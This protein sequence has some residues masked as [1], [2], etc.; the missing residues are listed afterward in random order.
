MGTGLRAGSAMAGAQGQSF[1]PSEPQIPHC[2]KGENR[3]PWGYAKGVV[4]TA[5]GPGQTPARDMIAVKIIV[6]ILGSGFGSSIKKIPFSCFL[7]D[8]CAEGVFTLL[9]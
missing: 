6:S 2:K 8:L 4:P 5:W 1:H 3:T 9:P 7:K